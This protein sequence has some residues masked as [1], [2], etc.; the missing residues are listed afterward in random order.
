MSALEATFIAGVLSHL[1]AATAFTLPTRASYARMVDG[2]WSG[3]TWVAWGRDNREAPVRLCGRGVG[4]GDVHFEVK[5]L[6]GTACPHL[7]IAAL[8]A[9]GMSAVRDRTELH[10]RG[11]KVAPSGMSEQERE[12]AGISARMPLTVEE[13]RKAL[14]DDVV[15]KQALG[16]EFVRCYLSVNKVRYVSF[17]DPAS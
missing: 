8:L 12:R 4:A 2:V 3:G 14:D 7:A 6:D 9:A 17:D 5:S 10:V 11:V 1:R 15:L 16:E 13:A